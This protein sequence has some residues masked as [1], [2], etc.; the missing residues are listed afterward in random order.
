MLHTPSMHSR[1]KQAILSLG[2]EV[3]DILIMVVKL[4]LIVDTVDNAWEI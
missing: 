1:T 4:P 2:R 3:F